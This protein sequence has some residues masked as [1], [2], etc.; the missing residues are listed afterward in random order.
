MIAP[1]LE[2]AARRATLADAMEQSDETT[3]L[4]FTAGRPVRASAS[5]SH[6][7]ALRVVS[8]GKVGTAGSAEEN[9]D[10][11]VARALA[12]AQLGELATLTLPQPS[13]LPTVVT[14]MPRAA[15][16]TLTDLTDLG[17][18]VRDRLGGE[19]VEL[20]LTIERSVGMVRV[21]NTAGLDAAYDVSVVSLMAEVSRMQEGRRLVVRASLAGA[22]LPALRDLELL[23]AMLRQRLAWAERGVEAKLGRQRVGFLPTA[24]PPLLLSVEQALLGKAALHGGSPLARQRGT[25]AYSE[26]VTLVDEPL[27]DGRPGSRPLDDEGTVSRR[28]PL[29]QAGEV[30]AFLYDLETAGRV[31]AT[32]TGHGRRTTFGKPQP[33]CSNLVF[34]PG[35]ASWDEVLAAVG[36]GIVV[37]LLRPGSQTNVMGGTFALPAQLAWRVEGGEI[38]GLAPE[39][40]VAGNIHD[41]LGRVVAVGVDVMWVGSRAMPPLVL[42]GVSVF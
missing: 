13:P 15:S 30:C 27:L 29:V 5:Y 9:P 12:S 11:L 32:P 2:R 33:A 10:E 22:D 14:H 19:R 8:E 38:T 20:G 6:G 7:T 25:R 36:D 3:L 17:Q 31:G 37:E 1:L 39:V 4:E 28:L 18:L 24:L 23:V 42:D 16:A 26:Q 41:L 34:E 35:P 21:A 40:T